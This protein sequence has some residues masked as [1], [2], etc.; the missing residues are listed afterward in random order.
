MHRCWQRTPRKVINYLNSN[1]VYNE[2]RSIRLITS[3]WQQQNWCLITQIYCD[4]RLVLLNICQVTFDKKLIHLF[5]ARLHVCKNAISAFQISYKL[6][7]FYTWTIPEE[8]SWL[9]IPLSIRKPTNEI[10]KNI[11]LRMVQSITIKQVSIEQ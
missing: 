11:R 3:W 1:G 6:R 4:I 2:Q 7:S 10:W 8:I 9:S 5:S